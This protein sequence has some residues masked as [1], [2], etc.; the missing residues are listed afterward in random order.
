MTQKD[1]AERIGLTQS[2]VS[3]AITRTQTKRIDAHAFHAAVA[4]YAEVCA[5]V[6]SSSCSMP[7]VLQTQSNNDNQLNCHQ[8]RAET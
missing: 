1:I 2:G 6:G 8:L 7:S 3:R 5:H 4:L